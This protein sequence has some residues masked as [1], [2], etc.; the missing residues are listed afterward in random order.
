MA[1]CLYCEEELTARKRKFCSDLHR[2]RYKCIKNNN[3]QKVSV[4]QCLR[5]ARAAR[6]QRLGRVGARFN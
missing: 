1:K 3:P 4:S 2:Y 6:S 5:M